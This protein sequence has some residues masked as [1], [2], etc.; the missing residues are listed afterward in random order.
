MSESSPVPLHLFLDA[1]VLIDGFFNRWGS[2]KGV[3]ILAS[4]RQQF[5]AVLADPIMDEFT[6]S[7]ERKS[8][9]LPTVE[10]Q[11]IKAGV[12]AW[13][14]IAR[15]LRLPWPSD[16]EMQTHASLL[17]AVRHRNDMPSVIAAILARPDWVLSTNTAH[18]N[19][20]LAMRTGLRITTPAAF[21]AALHPA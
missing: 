18:W 16:E 15:P 2:C 3:L 4:L 19:P 1:G 9:A 6:R 21:L 14:R 20:E 10:A 13:L 11:K 7:V 5:R 12:D 8:A 17:S